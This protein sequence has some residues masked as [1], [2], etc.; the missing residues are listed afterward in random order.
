[1]TDN[2]SGYRAY[3]F[4]TACH[5]VVAKPIKTKPYTPRTNGKAELFLQTSFRE[6]AYKQDCESSAER[7]AALLP[8]WLR[9]YNYRRLHASLNN[10]PSTLR[11]AN[12][13]PCPC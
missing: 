11:I 12:D 4:L 6:W 8:W 7:E 5:S 9:L 13:E 3:L 1:M 2:G 10:R